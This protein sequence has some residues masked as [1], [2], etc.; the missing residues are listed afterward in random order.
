VPVA[1]LLRG[2]VVACGLG[3][4]GLGCIGLLLVIDAGRRRVDDGLLDGRERVAG[5]GEEAEPPSLGLRGG[6]APGVDIHALFP[7]GG[8]LG[9]ENEGQAGVAGLGLEGGPCGAAPP[10]EVGIGRFGGDPGELGD[11]LVGT[12]ADLG[13]VGH[14]LGGDE[15]EGALGDLAGGEQAADVVATDRLCGPPGLV[16]LDDL[17]SFGLGLFGQLVLPAGAGAVSVPV[18]LRVDACVDRAG[19]VPAGRLDPHGVAGAA[20]VSVGVEG[21]VVTVDESIEDPGHAERLGAVAVGPLL[22]DRDTGPLV[23]RDEALVAGLPLAVLADAGGDVEQAVGV[24]DRGV[25]E[26]GEGV[27]VVGELGETI[28]AWR[29][30]GAA[31]LHLVRGDRVIGAFELEDEIRPKARQAVADLQAEGVKVVMIT[32][33]ARQ[34]ADTVGAELGI[35]EVFAEVLPEDKDKA[36]TELQLRGLS[37]AMVGD[38]VNDA[39]ALARADVGIA[40]GAGTDVAIE[41]AGVVLASSDPRGVTGVIR[42]SR[43]SHR[44]MLQ[45]L[46]WAAGYNVIAIPLA[47]GV[48]AWAGLTLSPAI[49]AILMSLSTIVVALN[50]QTLRGVDL[51]PDPV[52]A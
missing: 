48:L 12:S 35:D 39:P 14:D 25:G 20:G 26:S 8:N 46:A 23:L 16:V 51:T 4:E 10:V 47:A 40:I 13:G 38:G 6:A 45:N 5:S 30:R 21:L 19:V 27:V 36:V 43:A 24:F 52:P 31:V 41:S 17:A 28:S 29:D 42:L 3:S 50:A 2:D 32:G 22:Q 18:G 44:K 33:D 49:G 37:V 9:E 11:H 15:P 1:S 7:G 34:V